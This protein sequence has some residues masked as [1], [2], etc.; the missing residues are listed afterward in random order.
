MVSRAW[1]M[2]AVGITP[3]SAH[4]HTITAALH[5]ASST[6][7]YRLINFKAALINISMLTV[8]EMASCNMKGIAYN[9]EPTENCHPTL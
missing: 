9:D 5:S 6:G 7:R 2:F 1:K 4:T 3:S 8:D